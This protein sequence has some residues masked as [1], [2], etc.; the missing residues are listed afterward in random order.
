MRVTLNQ[1]R[2]TVGDQVRLD[3]VSENRFRWSVGS[4]SELVNENMAELTYWQESA[5]LEVSIAYCKC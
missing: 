1:F 5:T 4:S 2:W 3:Q